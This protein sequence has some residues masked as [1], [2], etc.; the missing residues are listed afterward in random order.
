M[1]LLFFIPLFQ[2]IYS[3][4]SSNFVSK[5]SNGSPC[6]NCKALVESFEKV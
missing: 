5:T 1:L 3:L 2:F 4:D 6:K